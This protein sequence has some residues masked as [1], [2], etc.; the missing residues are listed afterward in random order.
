V[1]V[2]I[3]PLGPGEELIDVE[4]FRR[5]HSQIAG[6]RRAASPAPL[7]EPGDFKTS[8]ARLPLRAPQPK[9]AAPEIEL[10]D[11][12][13]RPDVERLAVRRARVHADA[14]AFFV[15]RPGRIQATCCD[16]QPPRELASLHWSERRFMLDCVLEEQKA[17]SGAPWR[18]ALTSRIA[19][20]LGREGVR[21]IALI[22][23]A[24]YGR[25]VAFLYADA[26]RQPFAPRGVAELASICSDI[27]RVF[28]R[29][30]VE[31]KRDRAPG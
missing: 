21:Q 17:Y 29:M 24:V 15:A 14:A 5:L 11:R 1:S 10:V 8:W 6:A 4:S 9:A 25:S 2:E 20:S 19:R 3:T 12:L 23:I 22:P 26:G 16:P 7:A 30:L 13:T 27:G 31:I 18:D 28:E